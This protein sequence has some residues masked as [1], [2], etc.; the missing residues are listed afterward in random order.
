MAEQNKSG[1]NIIRSTLVLFLITALSA[2]ALAFV[3]TAT[4]PKVIQ[5][6]QQTKTAS[7]IKIFPECTFSE[8]KSAGGQPYVEVSDKDGKPAGFILFAEG[9]GYSSVIKVVFGI[10]S[11]AR[12]KGISI[13]SQKETPGLGT[14]SE[15]VKSDVSI[16]L[17]LKS[18]FRG[19]KVPAEE[20]RAPWFQQQYAGL[21]ADEVWLK[22]QKDSGKISSISGATV[23]SN[24]VT[25]AVRESLEN[26]LKNHNME[27]AQ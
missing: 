19:E 2:L 1:V 9:K 26:F 5:T 18:L 14:R 20:P 11:D 22:Q 24:A 12:I 27:Q 16:S 25:K 15:E 8:E 13:I 6:E 21:A 7:Y 10:G 4:R 23:T 17:I 3:Y